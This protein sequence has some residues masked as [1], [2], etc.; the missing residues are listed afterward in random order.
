M[1]SKRELNRELSFLHTQRG[2]AEAGQ[3]GEG[4]IARL[5]KTEIRTKS[6]AEKT[7][8]G[9]K[10]LGGKETSP[11]RTGVNFPPLNLMCIT[12]F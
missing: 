7:E 5:A 2:K 8:M 4:K 3:A 6:L 11:A 9:T 1:C 10:S 12:L